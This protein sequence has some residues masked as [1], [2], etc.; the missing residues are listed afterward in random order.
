MKAR[1]TVLIGW[2]V[3]ALVASASGSTPAPPTSGNTGSFGPDVVHL[4][5]VRNIEFG[6]TETELTRRGVLEPEPASCGPNLNGL[7]TVGPVFDH[8]RLV[9]M[10]VSPP[11]HTPEGVTVGTPVNT[12]HA[13]YPTATE[14]TAPQGTYRFDGLM[15]QEGDRA[16]LF[17]HDGRVVRKTIAGYADYAHKLFDEGFGLC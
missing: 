14:L 6:D 4:S 7:A 16:F 10:W 12:V 17:L 11:M 2:L 3:V 8:D 9:L 13:R 5:G 1:K 15:A